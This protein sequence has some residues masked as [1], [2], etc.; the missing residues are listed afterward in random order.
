MTVI[1][2]EDFSSYADGTEVQNITGWTTSGYFN[3]NLKGAKV[4]ASSQIKSDTSDGTLAFYDSTANSCSVKISIEAGPSA[5]V[6]SAGPAVRCIDHLNFIGLRPYGL[7]NIEIYWRNNSASFTRLAIPSYSHVAGDVYELTVED[8][9]LKA[10]V[11]G[12]QLGSDIDVTG[13]HSGSKVGFY[14]KGSSLDPAIDNVEINT[15]VSDTITIDSSPAR[16]VFPVFG[17]TRNHTISG[18]YAGVTTPTSI[19]YRIEEFVGGATVQDWTTLDASPTGGTYSGVVAVPK[20]PY[21]KI[22]TRYSNATTVLAETSR[23]GFGILAEYAGQSN[24]EALFGI[25]GTATPLDDTCIFDGSS[26]WAIPSTQHVAHTLNE[27]ATANGCVVAAYNTSVSAS[28]ISQHLSG[29]DYY[30]ARTAALT[31]A[32]GEL[33]LMYW[34]QGE[35]DTGGGGT[36]Q[37]DLAALYQDILTRTSQDTTTLPMFIVQL[38]RNDGGTGNDAGWQTVRAAQT[39]YSDLTANVYISHQTMDLPMA[40]ALHRNSS[41]YTMEAL[42]AADTI[43]NVLL[44]SGDSGLGPIPTSATI[45]GADVEILY[46]LNG[47]AGITLPANAKDG[48]E[49]SEDDFTSLLTIN[50]IAT[51]GNKLTLTLA[52]S[53][54]GEVKVRSQQGQDPDDTKMPYGDLQYN[55]QGVMV[56]PI[57]TELETATALSTLNIN[58]LGIPDG[59]FMTV[60]DDSDGLRIQ[61]QNEAYV[62]GSIS[63]ILPIPVGTTVKGYVD[64]SSNP[65]TNGAYLE[66]VTT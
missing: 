42:R 25:S 45:N 55:G 36:Y 24:T 59:T 9:V 15:L 57:V 32:G 44:D 43:N 35:G 3:A 28:S 11:N 49:V 4:N 53:P 34:G 54:T 65:S 16:K 10:F 64:D 20:G 56:T 1:L 46:N 62:N 47:S 61:R 2:Q 23:I 31:A 37:A 63:V 14:I 8:D 40:D 26:S 21:Y 12:V 17:A 13:I 50:S 19:E 33:S 60:L 58:I 51:L 5:G 39:N 30:A 22:R 27:L 48:Y 52:S 41:G 7:S 66:G 29:G 18:A 6:I 38:G